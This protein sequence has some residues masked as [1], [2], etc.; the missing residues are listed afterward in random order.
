MIAPI[1]LAKKLAKRKHRRSSE[2]SSKIPKQKLKK[3]T[4]NSTKKTLKPV[5]LPLKQ[6]GMTEASSQSSPVPLWY[7]AGLSD[8]DPEVEATED[9]EEVDLTKQ[10]VEFYKNNPATTTAKPLK[11]ILKKAK[12]TT[13]PQPK[14][15]GVIFKSKPSVFQSLQPTSQQPT[16]V[17]GDV[18]LT[19]DEAEANVT[20][21]Q[22]STSQQLTS[23]QPTEVLGD[24]DLTEDETE[25]KAT[26]D[27]DAGSEVT[28]DSEDI[29]F[30]PFRPKKPFAKRANLLVKAADREFID[31]Q[32]YFQ[33]LLSTPGLSVEDV[34]EGCFDAHEIALITPATKPPEFVRWQ[35]SNATRYFENLRTQF[36]G[37]VSS[38]HFKM[39]CLY[40]GLPV[41]PL[42]LGGSD[43]QMPPDLS[44]M[45]KKK[46]EP[47]VDPLKFLEEHAGSGEYSLS[48]TS[49]N[50][51][52][53]SNC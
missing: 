22:Q 12:P 26:Q 8:S 18:D 29:D 51:T 35:Y 34:L 28:T 50:Y 9:E 41:E 25:A 37:S 52:H 43:V 19:E 3:K 31:I 32:H 11:G 17:L 40:F 14:P 5:H 2:S 4:K 39:A 24:V 36:E 44:L 46:T 13:T 1:V 38:T 49:R 42:H 10:T 23:Q 20:T 53:I 27:G 21:S 33:A 30:G 47:D 15:G 48:N 45:S 16:E 6:L 7:G